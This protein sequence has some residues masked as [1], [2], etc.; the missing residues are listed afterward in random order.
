MLAV[1]VAELIVAEMDI[2]F[3]NIE[4][5]TDSKVVLGYIYNQTRRFYVYVH[6]RVQRIL[7]STHPNQWKY[8]PSELNPA[9]CGS[10]SVTAAQLSSTTWL[11]GPAFLLKPSVQ[12]PS[13]DNYDLV[14]P[15]A[16]TEIR[17]LVA[18][19]LTCVTKPTVLHAL[20]SS[21]STVSLSEQ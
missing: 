2:S 4:Y 21:P 15:T 9:D 1:E 14:D 3:D 18:T 19:N 20:K 11:E 16:D 13:P 7:Q 8:V 17:P 5:Y 6:N 10:R 12:V